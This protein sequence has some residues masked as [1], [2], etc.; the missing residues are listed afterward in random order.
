MMEPMT[1]D[2]FMVSRVS[3]GIGKINNKTLS[4]LSQLDYLT[5]THLPEKRKQSVTIT[6]TQDN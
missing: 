6:T 5:Q 1:D 4:L 3:I 2:S